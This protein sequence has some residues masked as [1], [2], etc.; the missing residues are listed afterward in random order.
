MQEESNIIMSNYILKNEDLTLQIKDLGAELTSIKDNKRQIEY[1]WN[2]D[3]AYWKRSSPILFPIVGS[4]RNKGYRYKGKTYSL[5]Q[6]GFA[7]D[8]KFDL[9]SISDSEIWFTLKANEETIKLFPFQ[10]QLEIGYHLTGRKINVMWRVI[11][12]DSSTMY[13]SIGGH[14]AFF[15]PL[16]GNGVQSDYFI[17]FDT[18][19]P[20]HYTRI[21]DQ[22]L[23][24]K[25]SSNE[26]PYLKTDHGYL[27]VDPQLF[28][29]DA[30]VIEDNQSHSIS[31][32]DKDKKTYLT[33]T[34]DAPLFG[35]WSPA[36]KNAPFICIEPWYGRCDSN[37]FT[38]DLTEREWG[39]KLEA[40]KTFEASYT[41]DIKC[42]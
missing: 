14:P 23:A 28:D 41:I 42:C 2:A 33:V 29:R 27:S 15:C 5:S 12:Q 7:R 11:N 32:A 35:L 19:K 31:L 36:G 16:D 1:L 34:F 38:G 20:L 40:G 3:P 10:F 24:V 25:N 6:H 17:V 21:D 9:K 8:M 26:T 4:L 30:L 18:D 37:S 22:G 39:N 13:F